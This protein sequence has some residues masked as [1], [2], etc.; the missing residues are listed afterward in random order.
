ML[1]PVTRSR[2]RLPRSATSPASAP[3]HERGL[4]LDLVATLADQAVDVVHAG[5]L[6][7][8]HHLARHRARARA[9]PRASGPASGPSSW[10]TTARM[11]ANLSMG[12]DGAAWTADS[13]RQGSLQASGS[14]D[15]TSR[16]KLNDRGSSAGGQLRR[17]R[18]PST[19]APK[20]TRRPRC[21]RRS[22]TSPP[23]G[24][25]TARRPHP[26]PRAPARARGTLGRAGRSRVG[27]DA[28]LV[29]AEEHRLGL[30][31]LDAQ[32]HDVGEPVV[33]VAE[34]LDPG[35][36]R[37][38][39]GPDARS[40]AGPSTPRPPAA[41]ARPARPAAAPN[42]TAPGTFSSP[43]RR[44]R[45]WSPPTRNGSMRRPRRTISA[46]MPGGP[47]SLW[48]ET[49][50]RSASRAPRSRARGRQRPTASTW[51]GTPRCRHRSTT[52]AT[53][54]TVPTSWLAHWQWTRDAA[55]PWIGRHR[56]R[57]SS[58]ALGLDAAEAVH[59]DG[60]DRCR[61]GPRRRGRPSARRRRRATGPR[62]GAE[63]APH[64]GV[65]RLG[66]SGG[67]HHLAGAHAEQSGHLVPGLLQ[68]GPGHPALGVDPPGSAVTPSSSH[69]AMAARASGR[70]GVVEA[71]SR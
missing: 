43:A 70:S 39:S 22:S 51:T 62:P 6:H 31:P 56:S 20:A 49:D 34:P 58:T 27:G 2:S 47:P 9:G 23:T 55:C 30:D 11:G 38:P 18:R 19:T 46:P 67:E 59:G 12:V 28:G 26:W 63:G 8:H 52:S 7:V 61:A 10:Q 45:S 14:T 54:W 36:G 53:G 71:W 25:A 57:A 5:G 42:P 24:A 50:T 33:R 15:K 66:P 32:A 13:D 35:H 29:E 16:K 37:W 64:G 4:R 1:Q 60:L 48:A 41:P 21:R 17:A 65:D 44:A 68:G 3:R 40:G 69:A